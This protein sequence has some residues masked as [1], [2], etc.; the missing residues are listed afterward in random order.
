MVVECGTEMESF[1]EFL[2][3]NLKFSYS[4]RHISWWT[5]Q[6]LSSTDHTFQHHYHLN[7]FRKA[8]TKLHRSK[9]HLQVHQPLDKYNQPD[10]TSSFS[11]LVLNI[12]IHNSHYESQESFSSDTCSRCMD[13]YNSWKVAY[14]RRALRKA[15]DED[16]KFK[17]IAKVKKIK[18]IWLTTKP[19]E[20][21]KSTQLKS[22]IVNC[23][24]QSW[25]IVTS[26]PCDTLK[27]F[28]RSSESFWVLTTL[29]MFLVQIRNFRLVYYVDQHHVQAE[30]STENFFLTQK[31]CVLL[32]FYNKLYWSLLF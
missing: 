8:L 24:K 1:A 14:I 13:A 7:S 15:E 19:I 28:F 5:S 11:Q 9:L 31:S 17:F 26:N 23:S 25:M 16:G 32:K 2:H 30:N 20:T 22:M 18:S 10:S 27:A 21:E 29:N 6:Q 4:N 3:S 12:L